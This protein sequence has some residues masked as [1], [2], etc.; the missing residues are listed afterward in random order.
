MKVEG[1]ALDS[2][3]AERA[4]VAPRRLSSIFE[5]LALEAGDSITVEEIRQALGDRS[6]ATLLVL[7]SLFNML[8]WPP[9]STLLTSIPLVLLS[10]QMAWGRSTVWMPRFILQKSISATQFRRMSERLVPRIQ[11]LE[12]FVRPRYWPFARDHAD[13]IIGLCTL[14]L[15]TVILLPIPFGNWFPALTC[16]LMGVA[17]SERDGI[18]FASAIIT[19]VLSIAVITAVVVGATSVLAGILIS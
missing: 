2:N 7:F 6:F 14:V 3:F 19:G 18:L 13:R 10:V 4:D 1:R 8:P 9:G 17:L 15:S 16:A 5:E 12:R 11:W